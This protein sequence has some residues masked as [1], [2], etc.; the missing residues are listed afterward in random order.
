MIENLQDPWGHCQAPGIIAPVEKKSKQ[1]RPGRIQKVAAV[2]HQEG[3]GSPDL[4]RLID[5]T[6]VAR[7]DDCPSRASLAW[8]SG[9]FLF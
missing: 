4:A 8:L 6:V 7:Q 9:L 2:K 5:P 1:G 3:L